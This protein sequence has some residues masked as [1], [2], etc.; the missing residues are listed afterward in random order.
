MKIFTIGHSTRR[1]DDFASLA[2]ESGIRT[3]A[4][5]RRFPGSKR[6]P[7]YSDPAFRTLLDEAGV[8]YVHIPELGGRR[9]PV[10]ASPHTA[11]RNESFRAYADHMASEEFERGIATLLSLGERTA[12]MCAEAVPWRCHRYLLSDALVVR[13]FEVIH[14]LAAGST[15]VHSLHEVATVVDGHLIYARTS[16]QPSLF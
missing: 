14:I 11:L 10:A 16:A 9:R 4:D 1:F 3:I 7:Q 13:G 15:R 6:H 8:G 5:V 12:A 2:N